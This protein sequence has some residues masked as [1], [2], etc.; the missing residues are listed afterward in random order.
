[1]NFSRLDEYVEFV[2]VFVLSSLWRMPVCLL[3]SKSVFMALSP[4]AVGLLAVPAY[5]YF[6]LFSIERCVIPCVGWCGEDGYSGHYGWDGH[7]VEGLV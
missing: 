7:S 6:H 3:K 4:M 2:K 5:L 1:M